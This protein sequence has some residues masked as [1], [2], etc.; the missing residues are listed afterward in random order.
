VD[1]TGLNA[2]S[3]SN[4]ADQVVVAERAMANPVFAAIVGEASIELPVAGT[5]YNYDYLVGHSGIVGIKTGST[6]QAG[7]C[8]LFAAHRPV[9][10]KDQLVIGAVLGQRGPSILEAALTAGQRLIDAVA[11]SLRPMAVTLP[12]SE[13]GRIGVPWGHEVAVRAGGGAVFLGWPGMAVKVTVTPT[14]LHPPLAAGQ[15]VGT[16]TYRVGTQVVSRPLTV[17]GAVPRP[18]LSWRLTRR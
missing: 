13:V 3:V 6:I 7:G 11:G 17:D 16:V 14:P 18:S 10:G 9:L 12:S 15:Q 2:G 5:L 1:S 4:A 8:F